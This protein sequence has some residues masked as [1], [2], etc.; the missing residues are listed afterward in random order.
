MNSKIFS[1]RF[2]RELTAWSLPDDL[3]EKTK[4]VAKVFNVSR[5]FAN[6][7]VFG[8]IMPSAEEL[9]NIAKI[10]G[11]CP[12]WLGG[13]TERRKAYPGSTETESA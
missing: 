10:L 1:E 5:Y 13:N 11:V 6:A 4:A 9:D 2:N 8:H 12:Q 7:M 3:A